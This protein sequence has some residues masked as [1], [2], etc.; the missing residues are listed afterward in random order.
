MLMLPDI[1]TNDLNRHL[2]A[3]IDETLLNDLIQLPNEHIFIRFLQVRLLDIITHQIV[4]LPLLI[5]LVALLLEWTDNASHYVH[6]LLDVVH[7]CSQRQ[8]A[9]EDAT[10]E[11]AVAVREVDQLFVVLFEEEV[12]VDFAV[13]IV[14]LGVVLSGLLEE[15]QAT[16][17]SEGGYDE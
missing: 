1:L 12:A 6:P 2:V 10:D 4:L 8:H 7:H 9:L 3:N 13:V 15:A 14:G 17:E 16:V 5:P 11:P